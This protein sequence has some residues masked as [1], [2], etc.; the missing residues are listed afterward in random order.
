ML[1]KKNNNYNFIS[2]W[3]YL[4]NNNIIDKKYLKWMNLEN[5]FYYYN[6]IPLLS[7]HYYLKDIIYKNKIY[8]ILYLNNIVFNKY[9]T[10]INKKKLII[11][12]KTKLKNIKNIDFVIS[13]QLKLDK[14]LWKYNI[15]QIN[16]FKFKLTKKELNKCIHYKWTKTKFNELN[17]KYYLKLNYKFKELISIKEWLELN[18]NYNNVILSLSSTK[19]NIKGFIIINFVNKIPIIIWSYIGSNDKNTIECI[20]DNFILN[21]KNKNIFKIMY[22]SNLTKL[23]YKYLKKN[24][25]NKLINKLN[26]EIL[27]LEK[28]LYKN[29]YHDDIFILL[30]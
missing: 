18:N 24:F 23:L 17:Y 29:F 7:I 6:N 9:L 3:F 21:L 28:K 25:E 5:E 30:K 20:M 22:C 8:K 26:N 13:D 27:F 12:L 2:K 11:F 1:F 16:L 15:Y 10:K 4:N 19:R 14:N